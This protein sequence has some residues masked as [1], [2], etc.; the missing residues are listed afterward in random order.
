MFDRGLASGLRNIVEIALRIG[1]VQ[2]DGGRD[3]SALHGDDGGCDSSRPAC[4]LRM[5]DLRFQCRHRHRAC[6]FAQR[7]L[8]SLRLDAVI[9]LGGRSV[10]IH[11]VDI[12][13]AMPAC[14]MA[15]PIARAGSSPHSF[16][17]T[18]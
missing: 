3:L 14:F 8:Q 11:V 6:P 10:E 13:R 9:E 2:I 5:A 12:V 16:R 4:T 17:R 7:E 15:S 1:R 18:R